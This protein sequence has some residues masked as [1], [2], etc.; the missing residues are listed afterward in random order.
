MY[1]MVFAASLGPVTGLIVLFLYRLIRVD[2]DDGGHTVAAPAEVEEVV[3][4]P[5]LRDM[6]HHLHPE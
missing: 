5:Q 3:K 6:I 1:Y 4:Q 2:F